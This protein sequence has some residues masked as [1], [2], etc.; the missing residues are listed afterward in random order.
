MAV[1]TR[2]YITIGISALVLAIILLFILFG[3]NRR[4]DI[5]DPQNFTEQFRSADWDAIT[6]AASGQSVFWYMW[7]GSDAI[8]I[9]VTDYLAARA[10][11]EWNINLEL[12]PLTDTVDAVNKIIADKRC[13]KR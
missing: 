3:V 5:S 13:G 4:E 1:G 7:G 9:Y 10:R 2:K 8:N 6:A 11:D 12:V